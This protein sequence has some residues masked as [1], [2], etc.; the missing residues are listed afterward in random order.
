MKLRLAVQKKNRKFILVAIDPGKKGAIAY[1][2]SDSLGSSVDV[3]E[4]PPTVHQMVAGLKGLNPSVVYLEKVNTMPGQGIVS[5]GTFMKG[6]GQIEG[7]CA[8]LNIPVHEI[9]PRKWTAFFELGTRKA[10]G[11]P[12]N[13]KEKLVTKAQK[14]FPRLTPRINLKTADALLIWEYARVHHNLTDA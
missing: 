11:S 13:W 1:S 10:A 14:M 7:A 4:M 9:H 3:V 12:K 5:A 2:K 6:V 8:A